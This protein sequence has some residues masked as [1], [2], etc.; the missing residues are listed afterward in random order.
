MLIVAFFLRLPNPKR[1]KTTLSQRLHQLDPI[2]TLFF[3]PT[4]VCLLLALQWGGTTYSWKDGRVIAPLVLCPV[5]FA[6]FIAVQS[7]KQE[8]ATV[9]PRI[10]LQRT[11]GAAMWLAFSNGAAMMTFV[12]YSK[13]PNCLRKVVLNNAMLG[14]LLCCLHHDTS[15]E[16]C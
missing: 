12:Y 15:I 2:G 14:V 11:V 13:L 10:F 3:L 16:N 4:V 7:W 1:E 5:F 6:V 8:T 9:P